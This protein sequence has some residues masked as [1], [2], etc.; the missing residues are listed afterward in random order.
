MFERIYV[1]GGPGSGKSYAGEK[2]SQIFHIKSHNLDHI[3]WDK[4]DKNYGK[5]ASKEQRKKGVKNILKNKSWIVEGS[6][7]K[8]WVCPLISKADLIIVL[9]SNI[10]VRDLRIIRRFIKK[11]L[12]IVKGKSPN[13]KTFLKFVIFNHRYNKSRL[14]LLNHLV[15]KEKVK[16]FKKADKAIDYLEELKK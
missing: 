2:L 1:I 9:N 5:K 6:Y 15:S 4:N 14:P 7:T 13:L 11:K 10:F 16:Y 12:G 3:F 8:E